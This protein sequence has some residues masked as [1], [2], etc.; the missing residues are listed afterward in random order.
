MMTVHMPTGTHSSN[1]PRCERFGPSNAG[2]YKSEQ[3]LAVQEQ[4]HAGGLPSSLAT[5]SKRDI[6]APDDVQY[7]PDCP[8]PTA[9]TTN[10][11]VE[12]DH[13]ITYA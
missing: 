7:N 9:S 10:A 8:L 13:A 3:S 5:I 11:P 2:K 1:G 6:D 4:I 12:F